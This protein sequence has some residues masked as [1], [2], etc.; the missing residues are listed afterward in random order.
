MG[1]NKAA[2]VINLFISSTRI[3]FTG[4]E[5]GKRSQPSQQPNAQNPRK[6]QQATMPVMSIEASNNVQRLVLPRV[7][8]PPFKKGNYRTWAD[9][10][11]SFFIQHKLFGIVNGNEANPAGNVLPQSHDGEIR[12]TDGTILE[13]GERNEPAP[14]WSDETTAIWEWNRRH[15][16]VYGFLKGSLIE[17]PAA[18]AKVI[19]CGTAPEIWTTLA[20][21]Y[22]Q[23]SNVML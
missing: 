18:Y 3:F 19:D 2:G 10:A 21:E 4:Y 14:L 7:N 12:F 8:F 15:T 6:A 17:E 16:L 13:D 20:K 11:K 23:S 9:M 22:G 1:Y 5:P